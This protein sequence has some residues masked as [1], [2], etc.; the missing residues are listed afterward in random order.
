M[1]DRLTLLVVR[2]LTLGRSRFTDFSASPEGIPMNIL[3]ECLERLVQ[4]QVAEKM[5]S[6]KIAGAQG[7]VRPANFDGGKP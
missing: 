7:W 2:D 6:R 4:H 5:Q 3:S 1:G